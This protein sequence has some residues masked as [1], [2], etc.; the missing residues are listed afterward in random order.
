V[1][2][3]QAL[4]EK[5]VHRLPRKAKRYDV[6]DVLQLGLVLRVPPDP[7]RPISYVAVSRR[8][9]GRQVWRQVGQS[10]FMTL[11]QARDAARAVVYKVRL[12]LPLDETAPA[13]VTHVCEKWLELVVQERGYRG[14]KE[15]ERLVRKH[16]IPA[17]GTRPIHDVRRADVNELIDAI[18]KTSGLTSAN[19]VL[20]TTSAVCNWWQSRDDTFRSP[21]VRGMA[22]GPAI[23]RSRTLN[24]TEIKKVWAACE[25]S[26]SAGRLCQFAL[27]TGQRLG[28]LVS[29]RWRDLKDDGVWELPA[30]S[31]AKGTI[32]SVQLPPLAL[33]ILH[34]QPQIVGQP[35]FPRPHSSDLRRIREMSG[36]QGW[37]FHD[38]RRTFRVKLSEAKI[39]AEI[40]ERCLGHTIG[41]T[42]RQTY[43]RFEFREEK[44]H[45]LAVLARLIETILSPPTD[46]IIALGG[47]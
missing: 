7:R 17:F 1:G 20:K 26:G 44:S 47:V 38:L 43:D 25:R 41:G 28:A 10:H 34:Q 33:K 39:D 45:A 6:W 14:A 11:A 42:A 36:V 15:R 31:R 5:G 18:A 24:D 40:C 35:I 21:I 29:M 16:L 9:K 19:M 12:N 37:V 27:L 8:P 30:H 23:K 32:G 13:T 3:R 46:N 2:K 4:T 22:R